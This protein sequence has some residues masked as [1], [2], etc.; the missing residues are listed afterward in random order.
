[1]D[2][3]WV[4]DAD[5]HITEPRDVWTSRVPAKYKDRVP[6]VV[7]NEDGV[8]MWMLNGLNMTAVGTTAAG[9]NLEGTWA[10]W[11]TYEE[12]HPA[13]YDSKERLRYMDEAGIWAQIL[14]PNV[15]GNS[16][17]KFR[18]LDDPELEIACVRA[19]NDFVAEWCSAN[20]DRLIGALAT[21][22][23]SV[24]E[25]LKEIKRG[26][27]LGFRAILFTG[28]PLRF[29][30]PT[31]GDRSWDPLWQLAQD[32]GIAF[33]FHVG[34]GEDADTVARRSA[35]RT[36]A[37]GSAGTAT[38]AAVELFLKNGVQC[39]DLLSSGV[40]PR[41][42]DL[43]FVSVESGCGW[44]PFVL[45]TADYTWLGH[46]RKGRVQQ[47]GDLLPSDLFRRQ[48]YVT[49]WFEQFAPLH[50]RD[51]LPIDNILFET[52]FPHNTC[53]YGN[54]RETIDESWGLA[55][56]EVCRKIVWGNAAKL[57]GIEEPTHA[58]PRFA[59]SDS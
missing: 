32:L 22:F 5:S 14:Y 40:L 36:A 56:P 31:L 4:I 35:P 8:D 52:D 34:G 46:T 39:A 6:H 19:Y 45:E 21:P 44:G 11:D 13:S 48:I 7:R 10:P 1:M 26:H 15:G 24:D 57:Y 49:A 41:Y 58:P 3:R 12:C 16:M 51:H 25:T 54:V 50:L 55:P 53:L 33:Y 38:Y 28:E 43:K 47:A 18:T 9:T 59:T 17:Q 2:D 20:P 37:H 42:P 29:G 30:L 27:E 23:W